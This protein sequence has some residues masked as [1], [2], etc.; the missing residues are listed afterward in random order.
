MVI[1]AV[2]SARVV[3][4]R[5]MTPAGTSGVVQAKFSTNLPPQS[6]GRP[7]RVFL[8]PSNI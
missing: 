5:S 1:L 8:Y 3:F 7:V 2:S 4:L 6:Y